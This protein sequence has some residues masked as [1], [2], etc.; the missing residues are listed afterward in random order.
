MKYSVIIPIYNAEKTLTDCLNSLVSQEYSDYEIILVNDGSSDQSDDICR[1]YADNY[2]NI[3]YIFQ[4]NS[5]VSAARNTGLDHAVGQYILFVDSDDS[6]SDH[7]F[8]QLDLLL[9]EENYDLVQ[10]S[11]IIKNGQKQR[12][13]CLKNRTALNQYDSAELFSEAVYKK[14]A[15]SPWNKLY[16]KEI[17]EQYCLRFNTSLSIGE[18]KAFNLQYLLYVKT[19]RQTSQSLYIVNTSSNDSLSRKVRTDLNEQFALLDKVLYSTIHSSELP[20]PCKQLYLS[21]LNFTEIRSVYAEAKR[22]RKSKVK[23][24]S[25]MKALSIL[26]D[27]IN[28]KHYSIPKSLFCCLINMTVRLKMLWF[29]DLTA[30]RLLH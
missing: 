6:V 23:F 20:D 5:G 21:A 11:Y 14:T 12:K 26:C 28:E 8:E 16:K 3:R 30:W 25:R 9:C 1:N 4:P 13:R 22:L 10:F 7:Y 24:W 27:Q 15:N 19:C 29:I 2:Q 17:I 18:D